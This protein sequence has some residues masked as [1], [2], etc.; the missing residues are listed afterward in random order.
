MTEQQSLGD[1][2]GVSLDIAAMDGVAADVDLSFACMFD[3]ELDGGL[4]G[5]LAHLNN[6]LSGRLVQLRDDGVFLGYPMETLLIRQPPPAIAAR[7]V[8]VI[9]MGT[10][11]EWTAEVTARAVDTAIRAATQLGANSAAFA[12]SLLDS[13]LAAHATAGVAQQMMRAVVRAIDAQ[14]SIAAHDLAPAPS[15]RR[16]V[17]DVGAAGFAA[18]TAQFLAALVELK[19]GAGSG[20]ES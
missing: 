8:M 17:F 6:V 9:G 4:R 14:I 11:T 18:A 12:P 10:P 13:G 15:L 7:A 1:W 16:W 2:R 3:H 5:G 20:G 19:S